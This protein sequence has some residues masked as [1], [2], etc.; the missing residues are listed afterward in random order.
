MHEPIEILLFKHPET[1]SQYLKLKKQFKARR[2]WHKP[3]ITLLRRQRQV[4]L[5]ESET[6]LVYRKRSRKARATWR[7]SV[8]KINK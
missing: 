6:S 4:D 2:W 1:L 8:L 5:C 3:L 7:N